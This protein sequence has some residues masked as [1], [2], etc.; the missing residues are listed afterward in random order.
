M[1]AFICVVIFFGIVIAQMIENYSLRADKKRL[2]EENKVAVA[3]A[4]KLLQDYESATGEKYFKK[5]F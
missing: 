3:V 4:N 1:E 2:K 5:L